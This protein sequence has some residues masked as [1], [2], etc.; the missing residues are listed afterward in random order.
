MHMVGGKLG[1]SMVRGRGQGGGPQGTH[2]PQCV[3]RNSLEDGQPSVRSFHS[4][5]Y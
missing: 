5:H 4:V 3:A 1:R 2:P